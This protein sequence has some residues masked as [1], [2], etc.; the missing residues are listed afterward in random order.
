MVASGAPM[1]ADSSPLEIWCRR[2]GC[3]TV[4]VGVRYGVV[5]A[6]P[7]TGAAVG[8]VSISNH[9]YRLIVEAGRAVVGAGRAKV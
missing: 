9:V 8:G 5:R 2:Q 4:R 7:E 3:S 6:V 1:V